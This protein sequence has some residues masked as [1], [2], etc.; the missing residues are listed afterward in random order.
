MKNKYFMANKADK[1]IMIAAKD[2]TI[3]FKMLEVYLEENKPDVKASDYIIYSYE[4]FIEK[5]VDKM[6]VLLEAVIY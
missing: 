1:N 6:P 3:A 5:F 2:Q 4:E